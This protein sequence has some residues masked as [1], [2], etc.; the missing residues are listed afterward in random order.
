MSRPTHQ[1]MKLLNSLFLLLFVIVISGC[2][3]GPSG[4]S[5]DIIW[6]YRSSSFEISIVSPKGQSLINPTTQDGYELLQDIKVSYKGEMYS[7]QDRPHRELRAIPEFFK[8]LYVKQ[9]KGE[10]RITFGEF[11]PIYPDLQEF[12]LYLPGGE[13]HEIKFTHT[14]KDGKFQTKVWVNNILH[15]SNTPFNITLT[16]NHPIW[17]EQSEEG[18]LRPITL[19][20][21][22]VNAPTFF[23]ERKKEVLDET[24]YNDCS[25]TFRGKTYPLLKEES[26]ESD[27]HAL[28]FT[29]QSMLL[30]GDLGNGFSTPLLLFGPIQA[31]HSLEGER[32]EL[33]YRENIYPIYL[34]NRIEPSGESFYEAWTEKDG[35]KVLGTFFH[36]GPLIR[37]VL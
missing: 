33:R 14:A 12:S 5:D 7:C 34:T 31:D 6:D 8:A 2:S 17:D 11:Q 36:N 1:H 18:D 15:S 13:K 29:T 23:A 35:N 16:T 9:V 25:L 19:Y 32:L 27:E 30:L 24:F 22:P 21:R 3:M 10:Y 28:S 37:W 26:P 4:K 20:I